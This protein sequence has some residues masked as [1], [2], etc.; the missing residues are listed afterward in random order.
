MKEEK[1]RIVEI[2]AIKEYLKLNIKKGFAGFLKNYKTK[3]TLK[4]E[5]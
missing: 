2:E 5:K 4:K 1:I 3:K